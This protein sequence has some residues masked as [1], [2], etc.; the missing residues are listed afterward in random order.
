[1]PTGKIKNGIRQ[2]SKGR[3]TSED[4][5]QRLEILRDISNK[6]V[7]GKS[8]FEIKQYLYDTYGIET[9]TANN[10]IHKVYKTNLKLD[11]QELAGLRFLQLQRLE[12]VFNEAMERNQLKVAVSAADTI[13]K[14]FNLYE[15]KYKVEIEQK[16][17]KFTFDGTPVTNTTEAEPVEYTE[18]ENNDG[19]GME[20]DGE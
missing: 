4:N 5:A 12:K 3:Q 17:I 13:N 9:R 8:R 11:E 7:A 20:I 16:E 19:I 14:L 6:L 15:N 10:Y 2:L 1:M 18:V